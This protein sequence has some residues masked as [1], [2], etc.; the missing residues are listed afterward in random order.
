MSIR[1]LG[2]AM[3]NRMALHQAWCPYRSREATAAVAVW[4]PDPRQPAASGENDKREPD[5]EQS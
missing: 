5:A 4:V 1:L 2:C 3:C